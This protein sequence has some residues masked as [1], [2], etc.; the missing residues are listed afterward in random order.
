MYNQND[1]IVF[2]FQIGG[3]CIHKHLIGNSAPKDMHQTGDLMATLK[4]IT[5]LTERHS[6]I[7]S[8]A[9]EDVVLC[10]DISFFANASDNPLNLEESEAFL[11]LLST[12]AIS[13]PL[14][15]HFFE[16]DRIMRLSSLW[17]SSAFEDMLFKP[18]P[19]LHLH[20]QSLPDFAQ[21]PCRSVGTQYGYMM[22]EIENFPEVLFAA[23]NGTL[24]FLENY[25]YDFVNC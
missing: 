11:T 10:S 17:L 5:A 8:V 12:Q 9:R 19:S 24:G 6:K 23:L 16:G 2:S 18:G 1:V 4:H 13:V 7:K 20:P 21:I 22:W 3:Q 15:L 25:F 14:L